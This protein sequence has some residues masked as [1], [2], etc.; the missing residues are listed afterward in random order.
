MAP[1]VNNDPDLFQ[2]TVS[3]FD[4]IDNEKGF[5]SHFRKGWLFS[6]L[7]IRAL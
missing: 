1:L 2:P 6:R 5:I 7:R 3:F 4:G